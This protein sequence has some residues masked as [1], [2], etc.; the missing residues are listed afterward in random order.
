MS[1][2]LSTFTYTFDIN[3]ISI[4]AIHNKPFV[5]VKW[6]G[7]AGLRL[8]HGNHSFYL[9]HL[10]QSASPERALRPATLPEQHRHLRHPHPQLH[11][12]PNF[13]HLQ[14]LAHK[15]TYSDCHSISM[16]SHYHHITCSCT[17]NLPTAKIPSLIIPQNCIPCDKPP[18]PH[19][20]L[21]S[22][23]CSIITNFGLAPISTS[24]NHLLPPHPQ[25][26]TLNISLNPSSL[27]NSSILT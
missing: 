17:P 15:Q 6:V 3:P 5:M 20:H 22:F 19:H 1:F 18:S 24:A 14:T 4:P 11:H 23:S 25:Y 27:R 7:L 12:T 10:P 9:L 13:S 16:D 26:S 2:L 21:P 8:S